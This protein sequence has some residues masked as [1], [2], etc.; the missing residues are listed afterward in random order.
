MTWLMS[1]TE[2]ETY[3]S[4]RCRS[5]ISNIIG[6]LEKGENADSSQTCF[7]GI[8]TSVTVSQIHPYPASV[9]VMGISQHA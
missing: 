5:L 1:A 7:T 6:K 3:C 9:H 4:I 2:H 8:H